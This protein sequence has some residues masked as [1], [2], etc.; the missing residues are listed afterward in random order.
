LKL[1]TK[2]AKLVH[3]QETNEDGSVK[4][5]SYKET[6]NAEKS[7]NFSVGDAKA[8]AFIIHLLQNL[9]K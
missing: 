1:A 2:L 3:S 8:F 9:V 5:I 7:Y 6:L 4:I